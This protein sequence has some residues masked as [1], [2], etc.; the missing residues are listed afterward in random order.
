MDGYLEDSH[1]IVVELTKKGL[2][3]EDKIVKAI[4]DLGGTILD[5]SLFKNSKTIMYDASFFE[6]E[7]EIFGEMIEEKYKATVDYV[8]Y[9]DEDEDKAVEQLVIEI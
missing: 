1:T 9:F 7:L 5:E 4:E 8:D 6:E 2:K 3:I